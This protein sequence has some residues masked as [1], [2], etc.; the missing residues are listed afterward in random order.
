MEN[1]VRVRKIT[2][3]ASKFKCSCI[4]NGKSN[5]LTSD[6]GLQIKSTNAIKK[7]CKQKFAHFFFLKTGQNFTRNN[8]VTVNYKSNEREF[9]CRK[10]LCSG[11]LLI[12]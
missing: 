11:K 9:V 10:S 12:L 4:D 2:P 8:S 7:T 1:N 6:W 5:S 3:S